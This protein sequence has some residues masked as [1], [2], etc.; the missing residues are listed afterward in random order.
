MA[1]APRSAARPDRG[2]ARGLLDTLWSD[3]LGGK[4]PGATPDIVSLLEHRLTAIRFC[5]VTQLLGKLADNDIDAM[6]LQKGDGSAGRWDPRSFAV[7]VVVPWN[8][9]N[10]T[11]LGPSGDPYVSNPLRRPRVD[12]GLDQMGD[13]ASWQALCDV[14]AEVERQGDEAYTAS[15]LGGVLSA[16]RDFLARQTFDYVVPARVSLLQCQRLVAS[17]LSEPSGGDRGLAVVAALFQVFRDR[18]GLWETVRRGVIN[19]SDTASGLAADLECVAG[20]KPV[21]AVEVK[22][23]LVDEGDL[24]SAIAKARAAS[25]TELL[26]CTRG[27]QE[28]QRNAVATGIEA[29]WASG[30]NVYQ[31]TIDDLLRGDLPLL[32]EAGIRA[33]VEQVGKQLD[34]FATQPRHRQAWQG[35]LAGL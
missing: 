18:F 30:T 6:C 33:F 3:A 24:K 16:A 34:A 1:K 27:V 22:E 19:A 2:V 21:L 25:V 17:F 9:G 10:Q 14:L 12:Q 7:A 8:R 15:V 5:L 31:T 13:R 23:R 35:L 4:T 32:G 11:V 28:T 29:A 26:L 20:G